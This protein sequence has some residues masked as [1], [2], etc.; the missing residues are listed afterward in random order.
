[1]ESVWRVRGSKVEGLA[2][3]LSTEFGLTIATDEDESGGEIRALPRL[4]PPV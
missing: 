2:P 4:P 3:P 1:M